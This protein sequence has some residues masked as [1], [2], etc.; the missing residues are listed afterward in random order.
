ML[1]KSFT[2]L[3]IQEFD[4]IYKNEISRKYYKHEIQRLSNKKYNRK[5]K[6]G[7]GRHFKLMLKIDSNAFS[8]LPSVHHIHVSRIYLISIKSNVCRDIQKI[9]YD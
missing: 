9:E 1:F 5:R 3:T 4:D 6:F 8:L 7:A 2:G